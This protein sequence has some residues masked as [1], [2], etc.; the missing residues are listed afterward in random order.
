MLEHPKSAQ[1]YDEGRAYIQRIAA[2][3]RVAVA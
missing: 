3:A 2:Q 1:E